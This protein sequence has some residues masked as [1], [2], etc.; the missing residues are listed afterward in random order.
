M[1][2]KLQKP[3]GP[4]EPSRPPFAPRPKPGRPKPGRLPERRE[5]FRPPKPKIDP[6]GPWPR[7]DNF[8]DINE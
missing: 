4:K 7:P 8:K 2:K 5:P 3:T 1:N 6:P